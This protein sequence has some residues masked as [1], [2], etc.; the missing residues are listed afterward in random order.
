MILGDNDRI[1]GE[2]PPLT[3]EDGVLYWRLYRQA[4]VFARAWQ[5]AASS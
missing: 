1:I 2:A 3:I 4:L 5:G